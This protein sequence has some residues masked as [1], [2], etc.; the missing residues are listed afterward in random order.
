MLWLVASTLAVPPHPTLA[1]D[2]K[3][4]V[5]WAASVESKYDTTA[6]FL[7]DRRVLNASSLLRESLS[8]QTC[9]VVDG[10]S[11]RANGSFSPPP[12]KPYCVRCE[13]RS[14]DRALEL[15]AARR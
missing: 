2:P 6:T 5:T 15:L 13:Y 12:T 9:C 4:R 14:I 8:A 11:E 1:L 10:P 3:S 7:R